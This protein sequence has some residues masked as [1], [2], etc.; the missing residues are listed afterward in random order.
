MNWR[1]TEQRLNRIRLK[2]CEGIRIGDTLHYCLKTK[3]QKKFRKKDFVISMYSILKYAVL[4]KYRLKPHGTAET[5]FLFS[6]SYA[7]RADHRASFK[8]TA[9]VVRNRVDVIVS[10]KRIELNDL[11]SVWI[12]FVWMMQLKNIIPD[13]NQRL[14]YVSELYHAYA[15]DRYIKRQL[16]KKNL[17]IKTLVT[18]CDVHLIDSF[19]TQRMKRTGVCTVTLQH[20]VVMDP[21][22]VQHTKSDYYLAQSQFTI[23]TARKVGA[24]AA[25]RMIPAGLM[26]Y[27]DKKT[28]P[29][30]P[31]GSAIKTIGL[32][33]DDE[34]DGMRK[35]NI[36]MIKIA[37]AYCKE[38]G[39]KLLFRFHPFTD[40][41]SYEKY[42][43]AG[44]CR[45]EVTL[46]RF[47]GMIDAGIVHDSTVLLEC[48]YVW[49]P[50]I[51][52]DKKSIL[53]KYCGNNDIL[54][55]HTLEE[56]WDRIK[57]LE[58]GSV[59][60]M[61]GKDREYF[62]TNGPVYQKYQ[63]VFRKIGVE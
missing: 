26:M 50:M 42:M 15:D 48:L 24:R 30:A 60:E 6:D 29:P 7:N 5:M 33:L 35:I 58:N 43:D 20:G 55:F 3:C 25:D 9:A 54:K 36:E 16:A 47:I 4:K 8:K 13:F 49:K 45:N 14:Y 56:L 40:I 12:C 17:K 38:N 61:I 19:I 39:K 10:V 1:I 11:F 57:Q 52:Y 59:K 41:G 31:E 28:I 62:C 21:W 37:S 53:L 63:E 23:D 51:M 34:R 18:F 22:S 32:F 2:G 44:M 27:A 46:D